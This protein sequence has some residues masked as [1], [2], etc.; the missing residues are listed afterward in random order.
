M[1]LHKTWLRDGAPLDV[2]VAREADGRVRARVG[3]Q[4]YTLELQAL[5]G[6]GVRLIVDGIAHD[7]YLAEQGARVCVRLDGTTHELE[8][9]RRRSAGPAAGSGVVEAP[10]TGTVVDVLVAVGDVVA[11]DRHV[12]VLSAMK[13]EHRLLAG[14]AGVVRE[15]GCRPGDL[16]DQGRLLVRVEAADPP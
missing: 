2:H 5:P 3:G 12:V 4:T 11:A 15:V 6:P 14:V 7:A 9:A 16:V 8:V 1:N 13:M 10:M